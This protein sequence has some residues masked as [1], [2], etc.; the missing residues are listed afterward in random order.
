MFTHRY[1][2]KHPDHIYL[3]LDEAVELAGESRWEN[4]IASIAQV[5]GRSE[6]RVAEVIH[7][8]S[9]LGP[10][11]ALGRGMAT[12]TCE[13]WLLGQVA[14]RLGLRPILHILARD[15][16]VDQNPEKRMLLYPQVYAGAGHRRGPPA[17]VRKLTWRPWNPNGLLMT[18]IQVENGEGMVSLLDYHHHWWEACGL[19]GTIVRVDDIVDQLMPEGRERCKELYYPISFLLM[20]GNIIYLEDYSPR[21]CMPLWPLVREVWERTC[22]RGHKP[23]LVRLPL[24][25]EID[26]FLEPGIEPPP[27]VQALVTQLVG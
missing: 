25:P 20:C 6:E 19:P 2:C 18:E 26:W 13:T 24:V 14:E 3:P 21:Y 15:R 7:P 17:P 11:V 12:A 9:S 4:V 27:R 23:R 1:G 10:G 5:T 22:A 8:L 16:Y